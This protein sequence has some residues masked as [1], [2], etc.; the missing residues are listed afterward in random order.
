MIADD[1]MV[2]PSNS[3]FVHAGFPSPAEHYIESPLDLNKLLVKSPDATYFV[4]VKTDA[5]IQ[6]GIHEQDILVI[7]RSLD[8]FDGAII[9]AAVDN[10]FFVRYL[11]YSKNKTVRLVAAHPLYRPVLARDLQEIRLFGVVT[12]IVRQ[13]RYPKKGSATAI[14]SPRK[15]KAITVVQRDKAAAIIEDVL[16]RAPKRQRYTTNLQDKRGK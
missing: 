6:A 4:R 12:G 10:E 16:K 11:T 5:M 3:S 14:T 7:D 15:E 13:L 1:T 8:A 2:P 9:V